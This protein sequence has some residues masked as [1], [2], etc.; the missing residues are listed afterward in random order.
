MKPRAGRYLSGFIARVDALSRRERVMVLVAALVLVAFIGDAV[1]LASQRLQIAQLVREGARDSSDL[2]A[3]NTQRAELARGLA[4]DPDD[5]LRHRL[6]QATAGVERTDEAF[7]LLARSIVPPESMTHLLMQ[8]LQQRPGITIVQVQTLAPQPLR[9]LD[10]VET[11]LPDT[12][13]QA[14]SHSGSPALPGPGS[15]LRTGPADSAARVF[16]RHGLELTLRGNNDEL[17][18]YLEALERAPIRV[19][20]GSVVMDATRQ[21]DREMRLTVYTLSLERTWLAF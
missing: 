14:A 15:G 16:W 20:F 21:A 7:Q 4:A 11:A 8:V 19:H 3:L 2:A 13:T 10:A 1:L 17:I 5:T 12:W 9:A 6:E 18:R